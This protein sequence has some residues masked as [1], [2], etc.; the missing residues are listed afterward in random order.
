[1]CGTPEESGV[2]TEKRS[3]TVSRF[4]RT[5]NS[6]GEGERCTTLG[7]EECRMR[8][9]PRWHVGIAITLCAW[10]LSLADEAPA[11]RNALLVRS[12]DDR[13]RVDPQEMQK[14][15]IR[16]FESQ[17][18]KL[19]TDIEPD[20]ARPLPKLIDQV[21]DEFEKYFGKLLPAADGGEFQV[22]GYLIHVALHCLPY[23][24]GSVF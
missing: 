11:P 20:A 7:R 13:P 2:M 10:N 17:R 19:F 24:A 5:G 21:F 4:A 23:S 9:R 14:L 22:N 12:P 6:R 8:V 15:G 18:L 1:M 16:I 3:D